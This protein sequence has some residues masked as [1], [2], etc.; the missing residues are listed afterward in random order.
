MSKIIYMNNLIKFC[1]E[2]WVRWS[3][4]LHKEAIGTSRGVTVRELN[5]KSFI[6]EFN[7]YYI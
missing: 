4:N 3:T 2:F 6:C 5:S 7:S 1:N